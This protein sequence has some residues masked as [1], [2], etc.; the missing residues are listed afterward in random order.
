MPG[1]DRVAP[2]YSTTAQT[3]DRSGSA[4]GDLQSLALFMIPSA[5]DRFAPNSGP[6]L[7]ILIGLESS[8]NYGAMVSEPWKGL[9]LLQRGVRLINS[10]VGSHDLSLSGIRFLAQEV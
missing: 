6:F 1:I 9:S 8:L 5:E 2:L 10:L 7:C 4:V 3:F